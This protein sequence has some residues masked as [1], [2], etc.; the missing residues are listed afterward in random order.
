MLFL[1]IE[2]IILKNVLKLMDIYR[3]YWG[4]LE[5]KINIKE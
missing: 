5:N 1:E 4:N 2:N 3:L